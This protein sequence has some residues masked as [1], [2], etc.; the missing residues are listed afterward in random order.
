MPSSI[1]SLLETYRTECKVA[2]PGPL[3]V[4]L[5]VTRLAIENGLPLN[6]DSLVTDQNGQV[7]GL[8]KGTIQR[9]LNDHGIS[10]VLAKEGGRTSRGSMG[11]MKSYVSFLNGLPQTDVETLKKIEQYWIERIN[12]LFNSDPFKLTRDRY[13]SLS[14]AIASLLHQAEKRQKEGHGTMYVGAMMQHLVGAKLQLVLKDV[15]IEHHGFSVSD[16]STSRAGD[17]FVGNAAIHV[18]ATPT[19]GLLQKCKE[20]LEMGIR[21]IIV[22]KGKGVVGAQNLAELFEIQS[23]IDVYEIEQFVSLNLYEKFSFRVA[24]QEATIAEYLEIYNSIIEEHETA[25]NL[26]IELK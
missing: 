15:A 21:P 4:V 22:T 23:R 12:D 1:S 13:I 17:F 19:E 18:T 14:A 7:K 8:G 3:S 6:A 16:D 20:N 9:I 11:R 25:Q 26:K 24:N 5:H 2:S 10:R